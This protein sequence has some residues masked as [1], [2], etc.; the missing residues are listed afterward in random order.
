MRG[1]MRRYTDNQDA[2]RVNLK[3]T[4]AYMT[5][6]DWNLVLNA[7]NEFI[8]GW[9]A[10]ILNFRV[11]DQEHPIRSMGWGYLEDASDDDSDDEF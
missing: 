11:V 4:S 7:L 5:W 1:R 8:D 9:E 10:L 6:G 2:P 3:V